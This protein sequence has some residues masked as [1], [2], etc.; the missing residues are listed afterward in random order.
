VALLASAAA[1][2]FGRVVPFGDNA[3]IRENQRVYFEKAAAASRWIRGRHWF[4]AHL[5]FCNM[6]L[7]NSACTMRRDAFDASGGYD[8]A[9]RCCEDVDLFLRLG[10]AGGFTFVDR[11]VLHY[12]VGAPSIM[13]ELRRTAAQADLA[14]V[15]ESYRAMHNRYKRARDRPPAG[16]SSPATLPAERALGELSLRVRRDH[17]SRATI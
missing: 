14:M 2:A 9:L 8:A 12:R 15:L 17:G 5:L 16:S 11:D 3:A 10:R 1:I 13:N 7:I 4:A 6:P